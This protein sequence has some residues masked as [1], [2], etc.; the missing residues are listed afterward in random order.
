MLE[1]IWSRDNLSWTCQ[2]FWVWSNLG[3]GVRGAPQKIPKFWDQK[4]GTS[5]YHVSYASGLPV[6]GFV[7]GNELSIGWT[8]ICQNQI[9]FRGSQSPPQPK[10][11]RPILAC[12]TFWKNS[13]AEPGCKSKN[14]VSAN[15]WRNAYFSGT[16]KICGLGASPNFCEIFKHGAKW[17][18]LEYFRKSSM[19]SHYSSTG[20]RCAYLTA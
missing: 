12:V 2:S 5:A 4:S 14:R 1:K 13:R 20:H 18:D 17:M 3:W 8:L 16:L 7:N 6:S 10:T 19:T 15:H 11:W 9:S